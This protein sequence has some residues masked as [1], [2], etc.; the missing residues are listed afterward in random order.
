MNTAVNTQQTPI[1]IG[2]LGAA[3]INAGAIIAPCFTSPQ[4]AQITALAAR[5]RAR[6][7]EHAEEHKLVGCE[8]F[9]GYQE[10]LDNADVDAIYVPSPNGLHFDWTMKALDA[11]FHV[12][13][14]KPFASNAEEAKLM[15]AKAK[16]KGLVL[17]EAAHWFYHPYRNRMQEIMASGMLG[18]IQHVYGNFHFPGPPNV[19]PEKKL[20]TQTIRYDAGLVSTRIGSHLTLITPQ[21]T[22]STQTMSHNLPLLVISRPFCSG[23]A[24]D[25]RRVGA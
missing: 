23:I 11:G 24:C 18:E 10:L 13:C 25:Y 19:P 3:N 14:E 1:R 21:F 2:V 8:I 9:D 12:L 17:M 6:A 20:G 4:D 7:V 22:P 16:E 15:V 5:D